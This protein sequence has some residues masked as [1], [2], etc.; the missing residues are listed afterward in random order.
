VDES[1]LEAARQL[2]DIDGPRGA[3]A[4]LHKDGKPVLVNPAAVAYIDEI[5]TP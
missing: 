5:G 3:Y 4:Q 2:Q 1:A